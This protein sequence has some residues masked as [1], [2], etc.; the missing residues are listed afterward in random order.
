MA[1]LRRPRFQRSP[2]DVPLHLTVRDV[3]IVRRVLEYRFLSSKQ[4]ARLVPG[5]RQQTL[6]RLQSLFHH[7]YLDRPRCQIDHF[8]QI[9]TRPMVYGLGNKGAA[10]LNDRI[11]LP[12]RRLD[13][14]SKNG[15][16]KRL[17]LDHTL[18]VA[19]VLIAFELACRQRGDT[20]FI[21]HHQLPFQ[22]TST[23]A[24]PLRW[25]VPLHGQEITIIPDGL[26]AL[27]LT[28][29]RGQIE[30]IHYFVEADRGTMPVARKKLTQTSLL[31]KLLA[32]EATW[33]GAIHRTVFGFDRFRV[34]TTTTNRQR[35]QHLQ[36]TCSRLQKGRGLF[37]FAD[38]ASVQS[39]TDVLSLGWDTPKAGRTTTVLS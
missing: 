25:K 34:L 14:N 35:I 29:E 19:E 38:I 23:A 3:E 31:R 12:S 9:G 13:W 33:T 2:N 24:S 16:A 22:N 8:H 27:E 10:V 6:R 7:G 32:Y 37:L 20:V 39:T 30:R 4:I 11:G 5:S 21:P 26:F 17:F 15:C 1:L 18:Q 28:N 36:E